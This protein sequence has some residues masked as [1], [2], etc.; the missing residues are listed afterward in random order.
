MHARFLL[1]AFNLFHFLYPPNLTM[2]DKS[3]SVKITL[4]SELGRSSCNTKR[5]KRT[6][7]KIDNT[8]EAIYIDVQ[9]HQIKIAK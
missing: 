1:S 5:K 9:L 2:E 7:E 4:M 3:A 8:I 6:I